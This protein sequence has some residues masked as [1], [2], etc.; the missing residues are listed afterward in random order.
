MIITKTHPAFQ[1]LLGGLFLFGL[2][3]QAQNQES[4]IS[5][6][7]NSE[8]ALTPVWEDSTLNVTGDYNYPPFE[9]IN[10]R[11]EPDGFTVEITKAV[12][13]V[14]GLDPRI[15]LRPWHLVR[16]AIE[17]GSADVV[18]GMY[19]TSEREKKVDFTIPHFIG[20]YTVFIRNDSEIESLE[21]I[22]DKVILVQEGDLAHDYVRENS[23]GDKII[24]VP[25]FSELLPRLAEGEG[26][27]A[28]LAR[29]QGTRFLQR[30]GINNVR[31]SGI[32]VVQRKYCMAVAEGNPELLAALNEGLNIIKINGTYDEI[33]EKW[34]GVYEEQG[35]TWQ[36]ALSYFLWI[37]LPLLLIIL[38]S[39]AWNYTLKKQIRKKTLD[40]KIE[41]R[42]RQ[43]VQRKLEESQFQ[44]EKQNQHLL[45]QNRQIALMN[46]DLVKAK[47]RAEENDRLKTAFLA[48]MSHEI[49]TPM[50]AII[51]FCGLLETDDD[52]IRKGEYTELISQSAHRLLNLLNDIIDIAKVES[53]QIGF[54]L[55]NTDIRKIIDELKLHYEVQCREQGIAFIFNPDKEHSSLRLTTDEHRMD[56]VLKNLLSN[57]L[58]HTSSGSIELGYKVDTGFVKFWVKD[59]GNGISPD[60][61]MHVFERFYQGRK[62]RSGGTG[63]GLAI[64][65]SIVENLGGEIG[66]ESAPEQGS[67]FWFTHP[68]FQPG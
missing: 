31:E 44:L 39:L 12:A 45:Y 49:R 32:T 14:M 25:D 46:E 41:L 29:L 65:K 9:F 10:D 43:E 3:G 62:N 37:A 17:E 21:D 23:M 7:S 52:E 51:G 67:T 36:D 1:L 19:R 57:A 35:F 66:V 56:Q 53:G 34:F 38:A 58:K 64:S 55:Q 26:D 68:I 13:E 28:I 40:L 33:Y 5:V 63:L 48:N 47:E 59:S 6:H 42:K 30:R 20:T 16:E 27:C 24:T 61:V 60:E 22:E 15:E 50:N 2:T 8:S 4:I 18:T 11:G 54:S